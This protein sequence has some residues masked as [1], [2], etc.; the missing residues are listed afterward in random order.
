MDNDKP[1]LTPQDKTMS[2]LDELRE[3]ARLLAEIAEAEEDS[4]WT[5]IETLRE[6]A[7][8]LSEI[9]AHEE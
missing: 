2:D 3:R 4:D 5:P 1:L 8:L 9:A 6:R 7:R